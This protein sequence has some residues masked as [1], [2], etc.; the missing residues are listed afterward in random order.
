MEAINLFTKGLKNTIDPILFDSQSWTFPT[1][2]IRIMNMKGQGF[3]VT[4]MDGNTNPNTF[5]GEEFSITEHFRIVGV[6]EYNGIA[7]ILSWN[8][9][10]SEGEIGCFPSP[11][12]SG[13]GTTEAFNGY[14]P[15]IVRTYSPLLNF[16]DNPH[17]SNRFRTSLFGFDGSIINCFARLDF[18]DS[19]NIYMVDYINQDRVIN[20]GFTQ[21][22]VS[23][24]RHYDDVSFQSITPLQPITQG[25]ATIDLNDVIQGGSLKYGNY[26]VFLRYLTDT[27]DK[28]TFVL[29]SRCIQVYDG[30]LDVIYAEGGFF[31]KYSNKKI[32]LT[33][34]NLDTTYKYYE[35]AYIRYYSDS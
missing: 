24:I 16:H 31:D 6:C 10:T 8:E 27:F 18:D 11:A 35:L 1:M 29:Q 14:T 9:S 13:T 2:N 21:S 20:S 25:L 33:L 30:T 17:S 23:T 5:Y 32:R 22:G 15:N 28:T 19:V 3:V 7:Y 34:T 12:I 26:F 4:Y